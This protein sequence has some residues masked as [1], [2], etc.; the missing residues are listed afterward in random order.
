M[1]LGSKLPS[2]ELEMLELNGYVIGL[3]IFQCT[4]TIYIY[5]YNIH[6]YMYLCMHVCMYVYMYIHNCDPEYTDIP[7]RIFVITD[8]IIIHTHSLSFGLSLRC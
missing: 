7:N 8:N 6:V 4:Y 3:S 2:D 5:I 1:S